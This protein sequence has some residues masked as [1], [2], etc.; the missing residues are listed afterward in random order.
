[1]KHFLI[2]YTRSGGSE[3]AKSEVWS[4]KVKMPQDDPAK[5]SP[6]YYIRL[7]PESEAGFT[8]CYGILLFEYLNEVNDRQ[9]PF[10]V[11]DIGQPGRKEVLLDSS[12]IDLHFGQYLEIIRP[13]RLAFSLEVPKHFAS[14]TFVM[15]DVI[16]AMEGC[17]IALTQTG[18]SRE[19][20]KHA[21]SGVLAR[22]GS[23]KPQPERARGFSRF[24][25][26]NRAG[27][28]MIAVGG[29][30]SGEGMG[31]RR[32]ARQHGRQRSRDVVRER[33]A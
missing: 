33:V 2:R 13:R 17:E 8:V 12:L 31:E 32:E 4:F 10:R 9:A 19:V 21:N 23:E 25:A 20:P 3:V 18:V 24:T 14:V 22:T 27:F 29:R 7:K 26:S 15:V 6:G 28:R 16:P 11:Y 5:V 30:R 1:M